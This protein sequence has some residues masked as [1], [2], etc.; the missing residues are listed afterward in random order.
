[1]PVDVSGD[2]SEHRPSISPILNI[3]DP[4]ILPKAMLVFFLIAAAIDAASSGSD[5]PQAIS[6]SDMNESLTPKDFAMSTDTS[7]K[8]SQLNIRTASP[9]VILSIEIQIAST[10]FSSVF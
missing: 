5:V 3:F 1:M 10:G 6:V 7:T 4:T 8:V 9:P 2:T